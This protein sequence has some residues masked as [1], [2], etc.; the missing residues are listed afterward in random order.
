MNYIKDTLEQQGIRNCIGHN[1]R[2]R[3]RMKTG[4]YCL[5]GLWEY[6]FNNFV[7]FDDVMSCVS[8]K[9]VEPGDLLLC[10]FLYFDLPL[11]TGTA[12]F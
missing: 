9:F 1:K 8:S 2:R 5:A 6:G 10:K 3:L 12:I 7:T 11:H 4:I